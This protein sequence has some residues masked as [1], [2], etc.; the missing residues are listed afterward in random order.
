MVAVTTWIALALGAVLLLASPLLM[1]LLR[2]DGIGPAILVAV[3]AVPLTITGAQAGVL[4][5]ERR[6]SELSLIYVDA[7]G[8][9]AGPRRRAARVA[10]DRVHGDARA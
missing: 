9:P 5:G 10:P 3:A 4:Q 2:L 8:E 7:R 1:V 6:W